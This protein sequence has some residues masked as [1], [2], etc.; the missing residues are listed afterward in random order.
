M[1]SEDIFCPGSWGNCFSPFFSVQRLRAPIHVWSEAACG[2]NMLFVIV[3]ETRHSVQFP[4]QTGRQDSSDLGSNLMS[5]KQWPVKVW[6]KTPGPLDL[7]VL[8][9]VPVHVWVSVLAAYMTEEGKTKVNMFFKSNEMVQVTK[10]R[11]KVSGSLCL[12]NHAA[13]SLSVIVY[14]LYLLVFLLPAWYWHIL[15]YELFVRSILSP[16]QSSVK[17]KVPSLP[18]QWRLTA[19]F[20]V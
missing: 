18:P 5:M 4:C 17:H 16:S 6:L 1:G 12:L 8:S 2:S 10:V 7:H 11:I 9:L 14:G 15:D 3:Q 19:V 13:S 20:V